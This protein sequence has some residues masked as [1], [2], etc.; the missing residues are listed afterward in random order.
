MSAILTEARAKVQTL[1]YWKRLRRSFILLRV[2]CFSG[3]FRFNTDDKEIGCPSGAEFFMFR[4]YTGGDT[5]DGISQSAHFI[6]RNYALS[7]RLVNI[8]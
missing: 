3:K 7:K 8:L 1:G 6:Y 5:I 2:M 4:N